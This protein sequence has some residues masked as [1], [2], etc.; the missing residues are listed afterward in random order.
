MDYRFRLY[1]S[2]DINIIERARTTNSNPGDLL[3]DPP[4]FE[5]DE[6]SRSNFVSF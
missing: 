5:D 2:S 1:A 4:P 3:S 6:V